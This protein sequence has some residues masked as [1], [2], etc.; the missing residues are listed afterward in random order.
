MKFGFFAAIIFSLTL[1]TI[2]TA[3]DLNL[4]P[5]VIAVEWSPDGTK[6]VGG[7][8]DG[9][10]QVWDAETREILL[11]F[12][13][14][15][16]DVLSLSWSPDSTKF[17]SSQESGRVI[18]WNVSDPAYRPGALINDLIGHPDHVLR[19]AWSPDNTMIASVSFG[20]GENLK[21]W[22]TMTYDLVADFRAGDIF[23]M[24]WNLDSTQLILAHSDTGLYSVDITSTG[25]SNPSR[26]SNGVQEP[27]ASVTQNSDSSL[28][29]GGEF[30]NGIVHIWDIEGNRVAMFEG[31]GDGI[32]ALAWSPDDS[33]LAS[34]SPDG[35]IRIWDMVTMPSTPIQIIEKGDVYTQ[36]MAWS[37]DSKQLA[38]G[39]AGSNGQADEIIIVTP[40][41]LSHVGN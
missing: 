39:G 27:M 31:H 2:V 25:I 36:S 20:G 34:A 41:Q 8:T 9:F 12:S 4:P 35:T 18:V 17:V 11:T 22:D 21:I 5:G 40:V 15:D 13:G 37:P 7:G 28:I 1:I 3:Q 33:F 26:I 38:Y 19:V 23:G 14:L 10:L 16:S 32:S 30:Y 6:I 29:A 24:I